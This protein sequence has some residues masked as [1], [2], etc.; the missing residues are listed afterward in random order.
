V[1]NKLDTG[2]KTPSRRNK[3]EKASPRKRIRRAR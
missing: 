3:F 2:K 1:Q